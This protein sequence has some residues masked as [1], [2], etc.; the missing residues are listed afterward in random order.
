MA[1]FSSDYDKASETETDVWFKGSTGLPELCRRVDRIG[2][3][4]WGGG[5]GGGRESTLAV[6]N[7]NDSAFSMH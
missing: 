2:R 6:V 1:I 7:L 5:G 3:R 4:G